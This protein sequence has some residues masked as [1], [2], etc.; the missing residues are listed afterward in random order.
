MKYFEIKNKIGS[1][2]CI[3]GFKKISNNKLIYS[4]LNLRL[5]F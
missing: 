4:L 1:K 5:Y 3:F 2:F